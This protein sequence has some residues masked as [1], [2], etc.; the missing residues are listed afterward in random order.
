MKSD[1][2]SL[3]MVVTFGVYL[4][5]SLFYSFFIPFLV[6]QRTFGGLK[7]INSCTGRI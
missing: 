6:L 3:Y 2:E 7:V 1:I 5:S 4:E